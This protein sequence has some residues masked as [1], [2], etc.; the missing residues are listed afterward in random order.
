M[1][2][3]IHQQ[4]GT[5]GYNF[6]G[7]PASVLPGGTPVSASAMD[8]LLDDILHGRGH[9]FYC[10]QFVTYVY[11]FVAEQNQIDVARVFNMSDARVSPSTLGSLLQN[12]PWFTEAGYM[13]PR[14]R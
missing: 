12:N 3:D 2:F 11:Q 5:V 8:R 4:Q 1:I 6:A 10:S 7:L 13:L 14:E 9:R